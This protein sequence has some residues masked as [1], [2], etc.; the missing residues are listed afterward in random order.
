MGEQMV[1]EGKVM[2]AIE[3]QTLRELVDFANDYNIPR[4]D[5]INILPSK[6]GYAMVYYY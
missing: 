1:K 2:S 6:E 5:I 4:E 3:S